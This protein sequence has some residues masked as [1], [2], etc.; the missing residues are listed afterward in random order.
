MIKIILLLSSMGLAA[1]VGYVLRSRSPDP[2][3]LS[4]GPTIE[5]VQ[6]LARLVA[7]RIAISDVHMSQLRGYTGS[8]RM[9]LLVK[10]EVEVATDLQQARF[11]AVDVAAHTA[12][13]MLPIPLAGNPRLD[14]ERTRIYC[15]DRSGLW[16][17][18]PGQAGEAELANQCMQEAQR[19]LAQASVKPSL[20]AEARDH[21]EQVL[22]G[23][24]E[25]LQWHVTIKWI[26][27]AASSAALSNESP[28]PAPGDKPHPEEKP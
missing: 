16:A 4:S 9:V 8:V 12:T 3:I 27:A 2:D 10:G 19:L 5:N 25:A 11:E 14:H 18:L 28:S 13:L 6:R 26:P 15:I 17:F 22:G 24:F 21:A 23:F 1:A 20:M 7:L